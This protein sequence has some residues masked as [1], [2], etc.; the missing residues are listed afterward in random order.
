MVLT[1]DTG[2]VCSRPARSLLRGLSSLRG[3]DRLAPLSSSL[4]SSLPLSQC[5]PSFSMADFPHPF[6][7]RPSNHRRLAP[8][9][10]FLSHASSFPL[11]RAA[12]FEH[13]CNRP[14]P[15]PRP[16]TLCSDIIEYT[17]LIDSLSSRYGFRG[18]L[19]PRWLVRDALREALEIL[20]L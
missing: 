20:S 4:V 10:R 6:L 1:L 18:H 9:T 2:A 8:F 5:P 3:R 15:T 14:H 19:R 12:L 11:F 7:T 13:S 17:S 16:T